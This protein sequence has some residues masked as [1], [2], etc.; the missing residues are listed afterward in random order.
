MLVYDQSSRYYNVDFTDELPQDNM[1]KKDY[2]YD[3]VTV[4]ANESGRLDLVSY[5]VYNTPVN[6]WII[7]RFNAII[8]PE[9]AFAG[10]KL[11]IPRLQA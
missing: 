3:V 11:K 7:A 2:Q 9:T 5:R 8:S 10:M 6:W 4:L 1:L